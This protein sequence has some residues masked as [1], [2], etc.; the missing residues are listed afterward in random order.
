[1][2]ASKVTYIVMRFYILNLFNVFLLSFTKMESHID[3]ARK[4]SIGKNYEGIFASEF[5]IL[6]QK[7]VKIA[8]RNKYFFLSSS[9]GYNRH[10]PCQI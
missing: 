2:I 10:M 7:L 6:A 1:M 5:E 8:A 4:D 3:S 9:D